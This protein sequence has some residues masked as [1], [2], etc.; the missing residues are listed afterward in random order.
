MFR[1]FIIAIIRCFLSLSYTC[2]VCGDIIVGNGGTRSRV[3]NIRGE[4]MAYIYC[5]SIYSYLL[6]NRLIVLK[7]SSLDIMLHVCITFIW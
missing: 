1:L 4:S 7:I 5:M 3:V 2:T 6:W